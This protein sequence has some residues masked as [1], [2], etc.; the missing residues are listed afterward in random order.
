MAAESLAEGEKEGEEVEPIGYRVRTREACH[1]S[2][3]DPEARCV[4]VPHA[5]TPLAWQERST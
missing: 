2:E 3:F 4:L 1:L 5:H